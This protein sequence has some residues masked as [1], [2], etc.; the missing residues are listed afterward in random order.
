M[1]DQVLLYLTQATTSDFFAGGLVLGCLGLALRLG[2]GLFNTVRKTFA[3]RFI[4]RLTVDNRSLAYRQLY[5]WLD[6]SQVLSHVRQV[7]ITDLRD[8]RGPRFGPEPGSHWFRHGRVICRFHR[9]ISDRRQVGQGQSSR[10]EETLTL[11]AY[12]VGLGVIHAW[13]GQGA[14]LMAQ[15]EAKGP[16]VHV[17]DDG[18]WDSLGHV[19]G[20]K[21]DSVI[22]EDDRLEHLAA[23]MR[24]FLESADWYHQRGVPWRRGYLLYGPPGT[25][26]SSVIRALASELK[27]A[28]ASID[29]GKPGLTDDGLVRAFNQAP[30]RALI[31]LEDV[32]ALFRQREA[33]AKTAGISF[34]G[35]LNAIDGV[36]AQEG[37][38]LIMTTNH[39]ERLDPALIRPGRADLHVELGRVGAAAAGRLFARFFPDEAGAC[40]AFVR[41]L[42]AEKFTPAELQGWLMAH[43]N[44]PVRAAQAE[45]LLQKAL[46]AA[47]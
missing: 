16:E 1:F 2:Q 23:D 18:Y 9:A 4:A 3:R 29:L 44:D 13:L 24:H 22:A 34:S 35:L 37:R 11:S 46:L 47:A 27:L 45:G 6:Q 26:K 30:E 32:D 28:V 42:G 40:A 21:L 25:G 5:A 7:R 39:I 41:R 38:A 10:M 12:G 20:R 36:G 33:E 8:G 19:S 15:A 43:A 31:T 17:L 14:V